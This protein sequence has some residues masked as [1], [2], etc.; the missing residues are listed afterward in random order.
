MTKKFTCWKCHALI[1]INYSGLSESIKCEACG[2]KNIIPDSDW[3]VGLNP[4]QVKKERQESESLTEEQKQGIYDRWI[5]IAFGILAAMLIALYPSVRCNFSGV[6]AYLIEIFHSHIYGR[7]FLGYI[8]IGGLIVDSFITVGVG[9]RIRGPMSL[10]DFNLHSRYC[11][12]KHL[13]PLLY[14]LYFIAAFELFL[15]LYRIIA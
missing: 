11:R 15:I 9:L 2:A 13:K 5:P 7:Y 12:R 6:P 8:W 3:S 14:V 10:I 4:T 1:T